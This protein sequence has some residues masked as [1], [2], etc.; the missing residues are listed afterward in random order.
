METL[1]VLESAPGRLAS[2]IE[3]AALRNRPGETTR[4]MFIRVSEEA[5]ETPASGTDTRLGSYCTL[6]AEWL[7]RLAVSGNVA[8]D[9]MFEIEPFLGWL[10]WVEADTV[11]VELIGEVAVASELV[12][13]GDDE[14][15]RMACIDDPA[16]LDSVDTNLP[17][18]FD[19]DQFL[20]ETGTP[21]PTTVET[22]AGQLSRLVDAVD[23]AESTDGYPLVVRDSSLAIDVEGTEAHARATLDA[24]AEGPAVTN[25]YGQAFAAVVAGLDGPVTLQ[26]GP[27]EAV[28][29][30]RAGEEFTLRFVVS[31]V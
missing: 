24:P 18:R 17:D 8:V 7:D 27:G 14:Q 22:T 2:V 4:E 28:A 11:R 21:M 1:A 16:L 10:D 6:R 9:A 13:T 26:T 3:T 5:I 19:G 23:R 20:D 25:D 31:P 15:V 30:V 12:I 29:F